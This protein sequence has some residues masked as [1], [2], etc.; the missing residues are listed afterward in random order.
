MK[1]Q[2]LKNLNK[3]EFVVTD[4]CTGKCKHCSQGEHDSCV[5]LDPC[6]AADAVNKVAG[7]YDI[8]TVMVFGGEP[9][10]CRDAV[11]E[12]MSAALKMK[13]EKRQIITNG[14]FSSDMNI[15]AKTAEELARCGVN[16]LLLSADAFHQE[17]I[18]M[19]I[20]TAFAKEV[21]R[22]AVPIRIQP[23]WLVSREYDNRY[24][25]CTRSIIGVFAEMGIAASEG[26][27]IFPEG[28]AK[29]YLSEYF[30]NDIP[31]NPYVEDPENVTCLSFSANGDL[32]N[33]N[34]YKN[35]VLNIISGYKP[36]TEKL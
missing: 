15:M 13:V 29:K 35:D 10:L 28:N 33:G 32:L 7:L 6:A 23:A 8:K 16:D 36:N 27:I 1:N 14:Y 5:R 21:Q 30:V 12:I 2:Y 26:N 18:P 17:S 11:Y 25:R 19:E 24:N 3:M 20:I 4:A 22:C 34:I 31:K 9:L